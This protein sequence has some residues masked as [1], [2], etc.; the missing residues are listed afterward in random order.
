MIADDGPEMAR[1]IAALLN[2]PAAARALG[3]R[4]ALLV[5][6]QYSWDHAAREF[7]RLCEA[8]INRR[9]SPVPSLTSQGVSSLS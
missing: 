2:D 4:A 5:R 1:A 3:Q 8:A 6:S 9:Q 7:A